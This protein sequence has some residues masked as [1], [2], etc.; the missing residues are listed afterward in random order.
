MVVSLLNNNHSTTQ[1]EIKF[2]LDDKYLY[3]NAISLSCE[4]TGGILLLVDSFKQIEVYYSGSQKDGPN[5]R[6]AL[7]TAISNVIVALRYDPDEINFTEGVWCTLC[8]FF[9]SKHPARISQPSS[10][11]VRMTCTLKT[12]NCMELTDKRYSGWFISEVEQQLTETGKN[13]CIYIQY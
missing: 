9:V 12:E 7:R 1:C 5:I 8:S 10:D 4:S 2:N 13:T 11:E 3:C 6:K